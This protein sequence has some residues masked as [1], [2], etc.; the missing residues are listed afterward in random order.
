MAAAAHLQVCDAVRLREGAFVGAVCHQPALQLQPH[1]CCAQHVLLQGCAANGGGLKTHALHRW[2]ADVPV[3]GTAPPRTFA[4][5]LQ[6]ASTAG[7]SSYC[8]LPSSLLQTLPGQGTHLQCPVEAAINFL[9]ATRGIALGCC[10]AAV[11]AWCG[12]EAVGVQTEDSARQADEERSVGEDVGQNN[13]E[14]RRSQ[15]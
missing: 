4:S 8:C 7:R 11:A 1:V 3:R 13:R 15:I 10:C 14:K 12:N 9:E 5:W 2:A 6:P